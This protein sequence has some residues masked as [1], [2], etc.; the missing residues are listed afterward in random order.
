MDQSQRDEQAL[1][2]PSREVLEPGVPQG[3]EAQLLHEDIRI[4]RPGIKRPV[5]I[6]DL[7]DLDLLRERRFLKLNPDAG[8]RLAPALPR[9]EPQHPDGAP[10]GMPQSLQTFDGGRLARPV[11]AHEAEDLASKHGKGDPLD[12]G[13]GAIVFLKSGDLDG[14]GST[15]I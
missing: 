7:P 6:Q 15:G 1:L 13:A 4:E 12:G 5:E 11:G 14:R 8:V 2:L 10:I 9:V 3:F